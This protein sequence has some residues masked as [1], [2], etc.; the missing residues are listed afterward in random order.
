MTSSF[1]S[2]ALG[3]GLDFS[4]NR[5]LF[6]SRTFLRG[7]EAI[8][9]PRASDH[10]ERVIVGGAHMDHRHRYFQEVDVSRTKPFII[11]LMLG[12]GLSFVALRYHVVRYSEGFMLVPRTDQ[13]PIRSAYA[14][15]REW[16]TAMWK[17]YPEVAAALVADGQT[18]LVADSVTDDLVGRLDATDA[19]PL[20]L[21]PEEQ[22]AAP[23]RPASTARKNPPS[24]IRLSP[25]G[26]ERRIAPE[27]PAR[28]SQPVD[29]T[30]PRVSTTAEKPVIRDDSARVRSTLESLFAPYDSTTTRP[31][32]PQPSASSTA[33][34]RSSIP[35]SSAAPPKPI[36]DLKDLQI[37]LGPA[38]QIVPASSIP[39]Q[40][41]AS[42]SLF[43]PRPLPQAAKV[44]ATQ[45]ESVTTP[46]VS[47]AKTHQL[48]LK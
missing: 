20:D 8:L 46:A 9:E 17:Q 12:A 28:V 30:S 10:A 42:A 41:A 35:S 27:R 21:L 47:T 40:A 15:V 14:D 26:S 16:G 18:K 5:L 33:D 48:P 34:N 45:P 31:A 6:S 37:D 32:V 43:S 7:A 3:S 2:L 11:G 36:L 44:A 23:T 39:Q 4:V 13:P 1:K 24:P 25:A 19:E 38:R 29:A 22:P